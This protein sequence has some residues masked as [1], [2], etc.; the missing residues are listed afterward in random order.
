MH[1][2]KSGKAYAVI[3]FT[4]FM[5][6]RDVIHFYLSLIF[7]CLSIL[8]KVPIGMSRLRHGNSYPARSL[9]DA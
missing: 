6:E 3:G 1:P 9:W 5:D 8:L 7:A 4:I 2:G